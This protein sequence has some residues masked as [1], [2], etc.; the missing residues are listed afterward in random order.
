MRWAPDEAR[1]HGHAGVPDRRRD[2]PFT[3]VAAAKQSKRSATRRPAGRP[4]GGGGKGFR[5]LIARMN[6]GAFECC[7]R[8]EKFFTIRLSTVERYLR[9][10]HFEVQ[11][12]LTPSEPVPPPRSPRRADCRSISVIRS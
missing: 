5:V 1:P 3:D 9:P 8:G 12:L 10:R 4:A 11:V 6:G 7:P 2:L